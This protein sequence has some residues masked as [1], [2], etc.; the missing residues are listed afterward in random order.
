MTDPQP[1]YTLASGRRQRPGRSGCLM[2]SVV[3][4]II[5]LIAIFELNRQEEGPPAAVAS[6]TPAATVTPLPPATPTPTPQSFSA[7]MLVE[8]PTL[9]PTPW[10]RATP[11]PPVSRPSTPTPSAAAC[12]TASW[13]A[14]Q[15]LAGRATVLVNI[16][17]T[18]RC[19]RVLQ[20]TD[21]WF[22]V[23]GY[24]DGDLIQIAQGSPFS[25]IFP[26]RTARFG[27]GLPGSIDW[28]DEIR[29]DVFD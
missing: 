1:L 18:N 21:V 25:E 13:D 14:Q 12:I 2:V 11:A 19:Q 26:G 15:M 24:R 28:Y 9:T 3:V 29:V 16:S 6:P 20:P 22:R 17:A 10:I 5:S 4:V 23:S 7:E 8:A 27:I